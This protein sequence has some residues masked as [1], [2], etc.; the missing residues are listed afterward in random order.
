MAGRAK[1]HSTGR[2]LAATTLSNSAIGTW[3]IAIDRFF[4][5]LLI[6]LVFLGSAGDTAGELAP[7][8][9][10][11][12]LAGE[13]A[14]KTARELAKGEMMLDLETASRN[15]P[16]NNRAR[17]GLYLPS[18]F[19]AQRE[20]GWPLMMILDPRGNVEAVLDLFRST[21]ERFGYVLAATYDSRSDYGGSGAYQVTGEIVQDVVRRLPVARGRVYFTGMSGTARSAFLL[22][23]ALRPMTGG[24]LGT[25]AGLF[26]EP[27]D[28]AL[29]F[30]YVGAVGLDDFNYDELVGV[31]EQLDT[32]ADCP[33]RLEVFDGAHGWP[34][35]QVIE[36]AVGFF[37]IEAMKR[38]ARAIDPQLIAQLYRQDLARIDELAPVDKVSALDLARSTAETYA[39]L[40]ANTTAAERVAALEASPEMPRA[41]K[42]RQRLVRL[43]RGYRATVGRWRGAFMDSSQALMPHER[44]LGQ[45]QIKPLR[46]D[47]LD[48][49]PAVAR[50]A[51][52]RLATAYVQTNYYVPVPL[53][54]SGDF[55]R[56]AAS[57]EI[58]AEIRPDDLQLRLRAARA[59]ARAD[60]PARA[61][62]HLETAVALGYR[63]AES[64]WGDKAFA[65]LLER[66]DFSTLLDRPALVTQ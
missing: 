64:L 35:S 63:D 50:S 39:Q 1:D 24:V 31:D 45:L 32:V 18:T 11:K 7:P 12:A 57:L 5:L 54:S 61:V 52:R 33:H 49:D 48:A 17:Y 66:D 47:A 30:A 2:K 43:E 16:E 4:F 29:G 55:S 40:V 27:E 26:D 56:A 6:G 58:A 13:L 25:A 41:E 10:A 62:R 51:R 23:R 44:S 59:H 19:D 8:S 34:P 9:T 60:H 46:K 38:G 37:E 15:S 3:R 42:Q 28:D 21:A 20:G 53:A 36:R 22:G 14:A 65:S